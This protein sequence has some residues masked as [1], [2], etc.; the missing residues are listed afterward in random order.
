M[1]SK[2]KRRVEFTGGLQASRLTDWHIN[3]FVSLKPRPVFFFAYDDPDKCKKSPHE[4]MADAAKRMLAAGFTTTSHR[5]RTFVFVGFPQDTFAKAEERLRQMVAI[6]FTPY[7]MLWQP[8]TP[9]AEKHQPSPEWKRFARTWAR[10]AII[11][12]QVSGA[13]GRS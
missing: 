1:L 4:A 7:A 9:S 12:T 2:Q 5:L 6:G 8:E 13:Q 11:Y 3:G 10:P